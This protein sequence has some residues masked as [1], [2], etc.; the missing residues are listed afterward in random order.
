MTTSQGASRLFKQF[1]LTAPER[2][3]RPRRL[4]KRSGAGAGDRRRA[5]HGV[6]RRALSAARRRGRR[7]APAGRRSAQRLAGLGATVRRRGPAAL[8]GTITISSSARCRTAPSR[9]STSSPTACYWEADLAWVVRAE[10]RSRALARALCRAHAAG[11]R[12]GHRARRA[13]TPTRTAGPMSAPA[14]CP[15]RICGTLAVDGGRRDHGR[16][17]RQSVGPRPFRPRQR[18]RDARLQ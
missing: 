3:F 14:S 13:R 1:G 5:W 2:P 10:R 12:Q 4:E 15:G 16:R 6:R 9:S 17:A 7:T 8:P 18:R 11:A